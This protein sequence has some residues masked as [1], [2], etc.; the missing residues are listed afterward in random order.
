MK[1][2]FPT[3]PQ[4][5]PRQSRGNGPIGR[6]VGSPISQKQLNALF[7]HGARSGQ[8]LNPYGK[9]GN[10]RRARYRATYFK[11][12]LKKG[13]RDEAMKRNRV[14]LEIKKAIALEAHELQQ[15]AREN[16]TLA[17]QTLVEISKNKRA[18]EATRIAAS[19]VILDRAYGKASQ[20]TISANVTNGKKSDLT[21][22]DLD[23]RIDQALRRAEE[24][25]T[26]KAEAPKSEKRPTD[27]RKYN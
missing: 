20:T 12:P 18:P 2:P 19:A 5:V 17:M 16:A 13:F 24:L 4:V 15:I 1:L 26:R 14:K 23:K 21:S 8:I 10:C 22:T 7:R 3:V 11:R 6:P 9:L 25:T 27:I